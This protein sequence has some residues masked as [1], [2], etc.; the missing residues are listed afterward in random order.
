MDENAECMPTKTELV[1]NL[2]NAIFFLSLLSSLPL[3]FWCKSLFSFL[4]PKV[5]REVKYGLSN[6]LAHYCLSKRG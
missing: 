4:V 3:P 1:H 6:K 2:S 5:I